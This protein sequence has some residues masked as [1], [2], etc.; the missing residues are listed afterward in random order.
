[1]DEM[2]PPAPS[3]KYRYRG[4]PEPFIVLV[5]LGSAMIAI[6]D[7]PGARTEPDGFN[8]EPPFRII[9]NEALWFKMDLNTG[10]FM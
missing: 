2:S 9:V 5:P 6:G 1:M 10:R 3:A 8:P 7:E 4:Y